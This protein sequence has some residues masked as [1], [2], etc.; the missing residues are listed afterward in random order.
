MIESFVGAI[1][2]R[3]INKE[4]SETASAVI[5]ERVMSAHVQIGFLLSRETGIWQILSRG[6][7]SDGDSSGRI[8]LAA[9]GLQFIVGGQYA[10]FQIGR[11]WNGQ[12]R[13]ANC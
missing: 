2:D 3:S 1:G 12:N 11:E 6:T 13:F 10:R 4:R 7:A 5:D 9:A 8:A